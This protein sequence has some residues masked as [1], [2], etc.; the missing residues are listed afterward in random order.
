MRVIFKKIR[1]TYKILIA[2]I[3]QHSFGPQ[4]VQNVSLLKLTLCFIKKLKVYTKRHYF[5][6][7]KFQLILDI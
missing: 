5:K 4:V 3:F 2:H 6:N 1:N 7:K